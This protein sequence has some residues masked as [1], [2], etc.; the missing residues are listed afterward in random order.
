MPEILNN[1]SNVS[2]GKPRVAGA[3][4]WAPKGTTL[5][6]TATGALDVAFKCMGYVSEDGVTNNNSPE[7]DAIKAWGGDTV[8]VLQTE[9]KDI[10]KY[11]LIESMNEDVLT[12]I[13]GSDNVTVDS[14]GNITLK[15]TADEMEGASWVIDMIM[16][17]SRAKRI[18]I[19]DGTITEIGDIVYKD[20]EAVGYPLTITDVTDANGV[21]HYEYLS[22]ATVTL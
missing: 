2:V 15:A 11:T 9:R 4:Y 13:Y 19:P 10:F 1:S 14:S 8:C 16:K 20:D 22:G 3:I 5:P 7:S 21:Y 6:T 17:G 12:A 18:V